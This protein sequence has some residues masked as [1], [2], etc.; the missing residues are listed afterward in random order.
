MSPASGAGET[1]P[2]LGASGVIRCL[3]LSA[4]KHKWRLGEN[5]KKLTLF[6]LFLAT[7][8]PMASNR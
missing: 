5:V 2:I 1:V 7:A 6:L 8:L 3:H 4:T